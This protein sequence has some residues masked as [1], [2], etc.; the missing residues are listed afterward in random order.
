VDRGTIEPLKETQLDNPVVIGNAI[1]SQAHLANVR[2]E[3][4]HGSDIPASY[5]IEETFNALS[6]QLAVVGRDLPASHVWT[7]TAP[8]PSRKP[9]NMVRARSTGAER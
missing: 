9:H 1:L 4:A 8:A 3:P 7:V 2:T 5:A 6:G